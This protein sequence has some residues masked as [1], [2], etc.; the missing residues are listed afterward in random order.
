MKVE[1]NDRWRFVFKQKLRRNKHGVVEF[2]F[3]AKSWRVGWRID[4]EEKKKKIFPKKFSFSKM[5]PFWIPRPFLSFPSSAAPWV[6][7]GN[8]PS[9]SVARRSV[10]CWSNCPAH[11]GGRQRRVQLPSGPLSTRLPYS[12]TPDLK[13]KKNGIP[14]VLILHPSSVNKL[15]GNSSYS[16]G[17][18]HMT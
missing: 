9:A 12:H 11:G 15:L 6:P 5:L 3:E 10:S 7:Y 17:P 14:Q 4:G 2:W 16:P 18:L 8:F 13:S 1:E